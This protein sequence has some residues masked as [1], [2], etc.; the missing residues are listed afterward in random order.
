M[1]RTV[2]ALLGAAAMLVVAAWYDAAVVP[3]LQTQGARFDPQQMPAI[4]LPVGLG[5]VVVAAGVVLLAL[6]AR[7]AGSRPVDFAYALAGVVSAVVATISWVGVVGVMGARPVDALLVLGAAMCF[8]GLN[9]LRMRR[10]RTAGAPTSP[11]V[12]GSS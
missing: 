5:Y 10:R 2:V 4:S 6:L 9:D 1:R 7:W 11:P 3:T 12:L 8:I